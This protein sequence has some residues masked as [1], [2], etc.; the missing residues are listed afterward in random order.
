[1]HGPRVSS[2]ALLLVGFLNVPFSSGFQT[3]TLWAF[4]RLFFRA[5]RLVDFI[6]MNYTVL[7]IF[8][9]STS[10]KVPQ[11]VIYSTIIYFSLGSELSKIFVEGPQ[12]LFSS[13][14][15]KIVS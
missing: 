1:M 3:K 10:Q 13:Q 6:L 4:L 9:T 2:T 8:R 14:S 7:I 15:E 11:C 12:S 5:V